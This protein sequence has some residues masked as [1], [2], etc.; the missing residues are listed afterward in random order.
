M[1][2][3]RMNSKR[4]RRPNVR[5][6]EIGDVS[7]AFACGFSQ[8]SN[9]NLGQKRWKNDFVNPTGIDPNSIFDFSNQKSPEFTFMDFGV[10]HGIT[11]DFQ[12]NIENN[13]PNSSKLA[14]ERVLDKTDIT[15][16]VVDFGTVTRKSRIM[17]RRSQNTKGKNNAFGGAWNSKIIAEFSSEDGKGGEEEYVGF[18]SN[19]CDDYY[20]ENGIK[21]FSDC[22][23]PATS[24]EDSEF[25]MN[26]TTHN[27]WQPGNS[28]DF[29]REDTFYKG[30][31]AFIKNGVEWNGMR[32]GS[33]NVCTVRRWLEEL[34]FGKYA[35][36]FEIHGVDKEILPFLTLEDLKEIGVFAVGPR[37][38]LYNAIQQLRGEVVST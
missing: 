37:R 19:T 14:L 23:T 2:V 8:G 35:G 16:S 28:V 31:G 4:Q 5:L 9:E 7:A 25:D 12:Q 18:T 13:N 20:P 32:Y 34:G 11:A 6:G 38:K 10:S 27:A 21:D 17:R 22:E 36:V 26:E 1:L 29:G 3:L 33:N 30:N 15:K 24:K